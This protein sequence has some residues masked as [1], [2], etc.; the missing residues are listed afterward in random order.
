[1]LL[2][3]T[4]FISL[5]MGCFVGIAGQ[6]RRAKI[7]F[8]LLC[9]SAAALCIGL[10]IE[11]NVPT[12]ALLAARANMTSALMIAAMGLLSA[13]AMCG[14]RLSAATMILLTLASVINIST[15][16]ITNV[17]LTGDIYHYSWGV[18]AV[19]N[20]VFF[21]TPILIFTVGLFGIF[22][23]WINYRDAHSLDKNR[24]KYILLANFFLLFAALDFLPHFGISIFAGPVSGIAIPLFLAT[25]SYAML[26]YRLVEFRSFLTRAAGWFLAGIL[27][28]TVYALTIEI[29]ERIGAPL[30]QTY[31]IGALA[32]FLAWLGVGRF[33]PDWAQSVFSHESDFRYRVQLFD[34]EIVCVQDESTLLERLR[35]LCV[36]EFGAC[37]AEYVENSDEIAIAVGGRLSNEDIIEKES[38]RR[39]GRLRPGLLAV[40]EVIFPIVR[41]ENILGLVCVGDRTDGEQYTRGMLVAL[42][43]A[44]NIFSVTLVN[45][46]SAQEIEKRHQLDRY[47]APGI[48]ESV[49]AG[50]MKII[51]ELNRRPITVFFSDL[52]DFGLLADRIDPTHLALVLNEYL[53]AMAEIVF[54]F[55]GTLDK[56]IG[57]SIM[58]IFGAPLE[59]DPSVQVNQCVGMALAMHSRIKELNQKWL[60]GRLL[61]SR[62][63]CRMGIHV[64]EATV[65]SFGSDNRLEYTAIGRTVNLASRLEGHCTP[66]HVLVSSECLPYLSNG[67]EGRLRCAIRLKGFAEPVDAYEISSDIAESVSSSYEY[68]DARSR[69]AI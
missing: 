8:L 57:D 54:I 67:F 58:V 50:R 34:D 42:R 15:V 59:S 66:G 36:H 9:L 12:W 63:S 48:V 16:W 4:A 38:L 18:Y 40:T 41:Q 33:L 55:G 60:E 26:R 24:A 1:M 3:F 29:G 7:W 65:G 21:I 44:V 25:Y 61:V 2:F 45:L 27:M 56:Y 30:Q 5:A 17:Y 20:R 68:A 46:R 53:S 37:V 35:T 14:W 19:G 23:L 47:L 6:E 31:I 11:V 51:S 28:V 32:G 43:H 62:L 52:K 10:W 64:G 13:R 49:L 69:V 22:N 39:S